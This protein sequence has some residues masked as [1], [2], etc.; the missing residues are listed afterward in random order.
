MP[1]IYTHAT[2]SLKSRPVALAK[3][4]PCAACQP[5]ARNRGGLGWG[6]THFCSDG[7]TDLSPRSII[8]CD[9]SVGQP[10][11]N[12]AIEALDP[13]PPSLTTSTGEAGKVGE[14]GESTR[15]RRWRCRRR[16]RTILVAWSPPSSLSVPGQ[17]AGHGR[18]A[19]FRHTFRPAPEPGRRWCWRDAR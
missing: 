16:E 9:L 12:V 5:K 3:C 13:F 14:A 7:D 19:L 11:L 10:S 18:A 4:Q 15:S 2:Y 1:S 6:S 17:F 8:A